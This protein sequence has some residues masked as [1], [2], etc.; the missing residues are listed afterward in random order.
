MDLWAGKLTVTTPTIANNT[1]VTVLAANQNRKHLLIQNNSAASIGFSFSGAVLT[2][3]APSATNICYT[4]AAGQSY[5]TTQ[6]GFIPTGA[7]T[8]YQSSGASIN[9]ITVGEG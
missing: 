9:T 4:L 8:I 7:I 2:G 5:E 3:T 1:S 6:E